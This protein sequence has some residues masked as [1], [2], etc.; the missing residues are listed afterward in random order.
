MFGAGAGSE[1]GGELSLSS[2]GSAPLLRQPWGKSVPCCPSGVVLN[3]LNILCPCLLTFNALLP[4]DSLSRS[5]LLLL[6]VLLAASSGRWILLDLLLGK[7]PPAIR[8]S[9]PERNHIHPRI[10]QSLKRG[11]GVC[12]LSSQHKE[13]PHKLQKTPHS[14]VG[15][16][17]ILLSQSKNSASLSEIAATGMGDPKLRFW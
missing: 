12:W 4:A 1:S 5:D 10:T 6:W 3:E 15:Y 7:C 9:W 11:R 8:A 2:T 17:G 16:D 14:L 13:I